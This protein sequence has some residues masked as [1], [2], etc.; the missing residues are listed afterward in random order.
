MI[1]SPDLMMRRVQKD[2]EKSKFQCLKE[3]HKC[4]QWRFRE[5]DYTFKCND[6]G[7]LV[8][9]PPRKDRNYAYGVRWIGK[10]EY[11]RGYAKDY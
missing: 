6:C 8:I 3:D 10:E 4:W 2:I 5:K 1:R 11:D 9:Y 7:T